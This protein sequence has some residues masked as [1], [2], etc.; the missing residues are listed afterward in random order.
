MGL[1]WID[2]DTFLNLDQRNTW[3]IYESGKIP[4]H[5]VKSLPQF[6][7]K[8]P[9][10]KYLEIVEKIRAYLNSNKAA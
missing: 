8:I 4:S 7:G 1:F 2:P 6:E 3:Y 5:I 10:G 9:S